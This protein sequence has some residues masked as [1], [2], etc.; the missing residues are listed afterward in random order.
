MFT[1]SIGP[2]GDFAGRAKISGATITLSDVTYKDAGVYQCEVTAAQDKVTLGEANVTLKVLGETLCVF[3]GHY[4][5]LL[6]LR[7]KSNL[8]WLIF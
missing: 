6:P 4:S 8:Y 5:L 7:L 2:K 1:S 3:I